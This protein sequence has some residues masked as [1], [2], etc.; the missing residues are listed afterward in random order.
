MYT[1][2]ENKKNEKK[3][4]FLEILIVPSSWGNSWQNTA[5]LV[6]SPATGSVAKEAPMARPSVKLCNPSP[7]RMRNAKDGEAPSGS[8][9]E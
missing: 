1:W 2:M 7:T 9:W 4:E 8:P 3:R 5:M 6:A